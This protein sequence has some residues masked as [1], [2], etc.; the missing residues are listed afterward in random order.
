MADVRFDAE[1]EPAIA[2]F[3][4][5]LRVQSEGRDLARK[6]QYCAD[7]FKARGQ[8]RLPRFRG[9]IPRIS[10]CGHRVPCRWITSCISLDTIIPGHGVSIQYEAYDCRSLL[11]GFL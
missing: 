8:F 9:Q 6:I 7:I 11:F 4:E 5:L 3:P 2:D 10:A 1:G